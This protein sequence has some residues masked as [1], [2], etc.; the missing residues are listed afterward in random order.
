[1]NWAGRIYRRLAE[2][3]PH[4]FKLAYGKELT[5]LGDDVVEEVAKRYGAAGLVRL[6]AD[7]A[8]RVPLSTRSRAL[9]MSRILPLRRAPTKAGA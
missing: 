9:L 2:A 4:E 1:M 6:I 5:Q 8:V 3:F 7:I